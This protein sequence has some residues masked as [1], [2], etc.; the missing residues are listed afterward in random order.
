MLDLVEGAVRSLVVPALWDDVPTVHGVED[1]FLAP[2]ALAALAHVADATVAMC[3]DE[4]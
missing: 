2:A 1:G 3:F 4:V